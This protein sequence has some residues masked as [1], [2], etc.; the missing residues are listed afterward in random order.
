MCL[1]WNSF[2]LNVF[3]AL[4]ALCLCCCCCFFFWGGGW[5]FVTL[6]MSFKNQGLILFLPLLQRRTF[7]FLIWKLLIIRD[8]KFLKSSNTCRDFFALGLQLIEIR[9]GQLQADGGRHRWYLGDILLF[10]TISQTLMLFWDILR[11]DPASNLRF[12]ELRQISLMV[13]P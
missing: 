6:R 3:E 10:L 1:G 12:W 5:W 11:V 13:K 7:F 9:P 4:K 8:Q 2:P